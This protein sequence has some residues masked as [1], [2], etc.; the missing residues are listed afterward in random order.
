MQDLKDRRPRDWWREVEQLCGNGI[1]ARKDL[2]SILRIYTDCTNHELANK[3]D[4]AFVCVMRDYT[5]LSDDAFV[6]RKDDEPIMVTVD[7]VA[8]RLS[9]ISASKAAGPDSLPNWVSKEFSDILAPARGKQGVSNQSFPDLKSRV[10][11]NKRMS[12][13]SPKAPLSKISTKTLGPYL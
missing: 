13:Q 4:E 5:P 8:T 1:N 2:R 10:F 9:K 7:S 12:Q 11:G 6:L 3:I